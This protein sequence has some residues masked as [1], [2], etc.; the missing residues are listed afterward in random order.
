ML[1]CGSRRLNSGLAINKVRVL[2]AI[3]IRQGEPV[4]IGFLRDGA[5]TSEPTSDNVPYPSRSTEFLRRYSRKHRIVKQGVLEP[6]VSGSCFYQQWPVDRRNRRR[7]VSP[8][9][10]NVSDEQC[11]NQRLPKEYKLAGHPESFQL[12][13]WAYWARSVIHSRWRLALLP[14]A[15]RNP[16]ETRGR[17]LESP[18]RTHRHHCSLLELSS[19]FSERKLSW[20]TTSR[21]EAVH[22]SPLPPV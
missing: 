12:L 14:A 13:D 22:F 4:Y 8:E 3:I 6:P 19:A 15:A 9:L 10:A 7:S 16:M 17:F 20:R 5:T 21:A 1:G 11:T 18:A 2:D